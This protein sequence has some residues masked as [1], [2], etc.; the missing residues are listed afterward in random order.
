[1]GGAAGLSQ[2][3]VSKW[4]AGLEGGRQPQPLW[5]C[6]GSG[7]LPSTCRAPASL[8]LGFSSV[9]GDAESLPLAGRGEGES[10]WHIRGSEPCGARR[11]HLLRVRPVFYPHGLEC[12][13]RGGPGGVPASWSVMSRHGLWAPG[14]ASC[15]SSPQTGGGGLQGG[16]LACRTPSCPSRRPPPHIHTHRAQ[17]AVFSACPGVLGQG[18]LSQ[19][20]VASRQPAS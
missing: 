12:C 3:W 20:L 2:V 15:A 5:G 1:M 8:C 7:H 17:D 4:R 14:Q 6:W 18:V 16:P 9:T 19:G 11:C 10:S 13:P